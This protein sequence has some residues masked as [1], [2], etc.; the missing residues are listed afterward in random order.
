MTSPRRI[1]IGVHTDGTIAAATQGV[2]GLSCLDEV[3]R[4]QALCGGSIAG[5]ILTEDYHKAPAPHQVVQGVETT[6]EST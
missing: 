3:A 6:E 1:V 4:I 2:T 5:S